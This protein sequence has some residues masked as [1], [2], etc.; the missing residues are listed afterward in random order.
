M[1]TTDNNS[2]IIINI[3]KMTINEKVLKK[4]GV[5]SEEELCAYVYNHGNNP[6][7]G[8]YKKSDIVLLNCNYSTYIRLGGNPWDLKKNAIYIEN[9][10]ERVLYGHYT[11]PAS[12]EEINEFR[13]LMKFASTLDD[14]FTYANEIYK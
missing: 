12:K 1:F 11:R 14:A 3:E 7:F 13:Q 10:W 2:I 5:N 9:T 8:I 4:L 6:E